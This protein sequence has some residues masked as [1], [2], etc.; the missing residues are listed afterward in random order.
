MAHGKESGI[1]DIAKQSI[2]TWVMCKQQHKRHHILCDQRGAA[3]R[4]ATA[5]AAPTWVA[6]IAGRRAAAPVPIQSRIARIG[7]APEEKEH[8]YHYMLI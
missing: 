2:T 6:G 5:I 7:R 3:T 1:I 4:A 8:H